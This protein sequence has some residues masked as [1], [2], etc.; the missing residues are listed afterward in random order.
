MLVGFEAIRNHN[1]NWLISITR[2]DMRQPILM[3]KSSR[4]RLRLFRMLQGFPHGAPSE[5]STL[6]T[7]RHV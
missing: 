6:H 1:I 3:V 5:E 4:F 7:G 2:T